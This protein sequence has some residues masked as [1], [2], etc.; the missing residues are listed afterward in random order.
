M[1]YNVTVEPAGEGYAG[2]S[3]S[4]SWSY[5]GSYR[6]PDGADAC[7]KAAIRRAV[8]R[9]KAV[10][11]PPQREAIQARVA[12][13]EAVRFDTDSQSLAIPGHRSIRPG[14]TIRLTSGD[15]GGPRH[16]G[17]FNGVRGLCRIASIDRDGEG[18][19]WADVTF[20]DIAQTGPRSG[21]PVGSMVTVLL[22]GPAYKHP[23]IPNY[24]VRPY[25][26]ISSNRTFESGAAMV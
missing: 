25:K 10:S 15:N 5:A 3:D 22:D 2:T 8:Q 26:W 11:A 20:I 21:T 18:R 19:Y 13:P 6:Y 12:E 9:E 1:K 4:G 16:H 14:C 24:I 7:E 17:E 23:S